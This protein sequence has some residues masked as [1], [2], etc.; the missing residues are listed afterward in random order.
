M[1]YSVFRS[2]GLSVIPLEPFKKYPMKGLNE[3]ETFCTELPSPEIVAGWDRLSKITD[4][5][6]YGLCLGP[7]SGLIAIDIDSEEYID[8]VPESSYVKKGKKGETRF[9]RYNGEKAQ[10]FHKIGIE[11]LSLGNQTAIP[12]SFHPDTGRQYVWTGMYEGF[13]SRM[14]LEYLPE[15]FIEKLE[16]MA[17][18]VKVEESEAVKAGRHVSLVKVMTALVA[19]GKP[20]EEIRAE[21]LAYDKKNHKPQYFT[22]PSGQSIEY[23][24]K[25]ML[26]SLGGVTLSDPTHIDMTGLL[27][28]SKPAVSTVSVEAAASKMSIDDIEDE[29]DDENNGGAF[30]PCKPPAIGFLEPRGLMKEV[31]D[32]VRMR[33]TQEATK[34]LATAAALSFMSMLCARKFWGV[35]SD[36]STGNEGGDDITPNLYSVGLAGSGMGKEAPQRV[37]R[38]ILTKRGL[39]DSSKSKSGSALIKGLKLLPVRLDLLDEAHQ[40][41]ES[42]SSTQAHLKEIADFY[43]SLYSGAASTFGG[44]KMADATQTVSQLLKPHVSLFGLTTPVSFRE[45]IQAKMTGNGFFGRMFFFNCGNAKIDTTRLTPNWSPAEYGDKLRRLD[46]SFELVRKIQEALNGGNMVADDVQV[47][48]PMTTAAFAESNYFHAEAMKFVT[49]NEGHFSNSIYARYR[50]NA[51][52]LALLDHLSLVFD[53]A[54]NGEPI[55]RAVEEDSIQWGQAIT[56]A[57]FGSIYPELEALMSSGKDYDQVANRVLSVVGQSGDYGIPLNILNRRFRDKRVYIEVLRNLTN[58]GEL[59]AVD[60]KAPGKRQVA[61]RVLNKVQIR[62]LIKKGIISSQSIKKR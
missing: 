19:Q 51:A 42:A 43:L 58:L 7:A 13:I 20:N 16:T 8:V 55:R 61:K 30:D 62:Q 21:L 28:S 48:V 54:L 11:V 5:L 2:Q 44:S 37:L 50:E 17:N 53:A 57:S 52:K 12:P 23:F 46:R 22:D 18:R 47:T 14:D 59:Y 38:D 4:G 34:P 10:K 40:L 41:F 39:V 45:S 26:K 35:I 1:S 60:L 56:V 15:G 31:Y 36:G 9:F 25:T 3:W 49:E 27:N 32:L 6:G 29:E 24:M 33:S